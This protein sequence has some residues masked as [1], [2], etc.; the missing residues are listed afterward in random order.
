LNRL[1]AGWVGRE[2]AWCAARRTFLF[3]QTWATPPGFLRVLLRYNAY[4]VCFGRAFSF[5][6]CRLF[7]SSVSY[8]LD[9]FCKTATFRLLPL[10]M[11]GVAVQTFVGSR[12]LFSTPLYPAPDWVWT[13]PPLPVAPS[14]RCGRSLRWFEFILDLLVTWRAAFC[15]P[16]PAACGHWKVSP[17]VLG[18]PLFINRRGLNGERDN[19]RCRSYRLFSTVTP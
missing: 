8:A 17:W 4:C 9:V 19:V 3:R 7:V 12:L 5:P 1:R 14:Y 13:Y 16:T 6:T 15:L 2:Q 18:S 10:G 11:R